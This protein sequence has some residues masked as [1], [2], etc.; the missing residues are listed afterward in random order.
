MKVRVWNTY[1]V[2]NIKIGHSFA[3]EQLHQIRVTLIG[4]LDQR[5]PTLLSNK[6]GKQQDNSKHKNNSIQELNSYV[7]YYMYKKNTLNYNC[8]NAFNNLINLCM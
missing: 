1:I 5:R 3:A 6:K 8:S 4:R 2:L 7:L